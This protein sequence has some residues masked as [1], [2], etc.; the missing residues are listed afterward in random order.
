ME[1]ENRIVRFDWRHDR[2][3]ISQITVR[4]SGQEKEV[5]RLLVESGGRVCDREELMDVVWGARAGHMDELYLTQL[6]YRLRKSLRPL[7]LA[8]HIVTMPR[9]GYRFDPQGL[10]IDR[11]EPAAEGHLATEHVSAAE[12]QVHRRAT[13][14]RDWL[15]RLRGKA[16]VAPP[17]SESIDLPAID[18]EHGLVTHAGATVH[19]TGF[20]RA[21]LQ[22]F[23]EHADVTLERHELIARIWGDDEQVDMNRLTR[24]VSRLRRS[25]Q[26]LGLEQQL[27]HIPCVGYRFC[28]CVPP[29]PLPAHPSDLACDPPAESHSGWRATLRQIAGIGNLPAASASR[30][31]V[32]AVLDAAMQ[33]V[34][35]LASRLTVMLVGVGLFAL[36]AAL[37]TPAE[38]GNP[39]RAGDA[40]RPERNR[41]AIRARCSVDYIHRVFIRDVTDS[42]A[43]SIP[44]AAADDAWQQ[45]VLDLHAAG[46]PQAVASRITP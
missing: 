24:L 44:G 36:A 39:S 13:A 41:Q 11:D 21:L 43:R 33:H 16:A 45:V 25:L 29:S 19:L 10:Q 27:I 30:R 31:R 18:A 3:S 20:E 40:G 5:L 9:A 2:V 4:V 6:I 17:S 28:R 34:P 8:D 35:R 37:A 42:M 7:D 1:R 32:A 38:L 14:M 15:A 46:C 26:P 23:I 12:R 22:V